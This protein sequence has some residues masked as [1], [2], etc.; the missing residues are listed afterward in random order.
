MTWME[1]EQSR[2]VFLLLRFKVLQLMD[3][4]RNVM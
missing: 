4:L 3:P 1:T 2:Q